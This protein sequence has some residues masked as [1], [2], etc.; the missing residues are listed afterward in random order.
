MVGSISK[1]YQDIRNHLEF[2]SFQSCFIGLLEADRGRIYIALSRIDIT[3]YIKTF[4][5]QIGQPMRKRLS[6]SKRLN[7]PEQ[8][9]CGVEVG[10]SQTGFQGNSKI[11][12]PHHTIFGPFHSL[13]CLCFH[14]ARRHHY[15]IAVSAEKRIEFL[16]FKNSATAAFIST[17][18]RQ[19]HCQT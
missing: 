14:P 17:G 16:H 4:G 13:Q 11:I 1:I 12:I 15:G 5:L 18:T 19:C 6:A 2:C 7:L 10:S 3:L 8:K 9:L